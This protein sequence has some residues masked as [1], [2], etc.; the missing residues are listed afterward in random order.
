MRLLLSL[1]AFLFMAAAAQA[2][3]WVIKS[4]PHDVP[5][6]A[7]RLEAAIDAGPANLLA[8]V[9]HQKSAAD[10]G[11]EMVPATVLIFG[12]P[13]VGT[14]LMQQNPMVALDL[15]AR[16]LVWQGTDGT[17]VGYL[18][19]EELADRYDITGADDAVGKLSGALDM[20]TDSA[21]AE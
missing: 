6:T 11:L 18:K 3:D 13:A 8:R 9:D 4:S 17:K 15:P 12:N 21:I 1:T 2:D 7:D 10:A 16:V 14:P 20:L 19:P 5:T